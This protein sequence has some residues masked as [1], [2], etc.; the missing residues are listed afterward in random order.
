VAHSGRLGVVDRASRAARHETGDILLLDPYRKHALVPEGR[1]AREHPYERAHG[2][3]TNPEDQ[4]VF[5][6][7]DVKRPLL[8]DR[9]RLPEKGR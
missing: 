2:L 7:F 8:R 3:V 9:F 1:T 5:L 6:D 4:F